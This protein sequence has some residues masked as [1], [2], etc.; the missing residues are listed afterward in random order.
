[1]QMN[2][3][4]KGELMDLLTKADPRLSTLSVPELTRAMQAV[5]RMEVD[6]KSD[7]EDQNIM[8]GQQQ[9]QAVARGRAANMQQS[10]QALDPI[11][12]L[13]SGGR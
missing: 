4:E 3:K 11:E 1:M 9:T 2:E 7:I 10:R 5:A 6:N 12:A 13:I 8:F